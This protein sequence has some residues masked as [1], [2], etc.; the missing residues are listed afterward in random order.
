MLTHIHITN[1]TI[2]D[3]LELTL[4]PGMTVLTGETGAGKSIIIDALG[5]VLGGRADSSLVRHG[6]ERCNITATFT[7]DAGSLA[8]TWLHNYEFDADNDCIIRRT[9]SPDGK[10]KAYINGCPVT[11]QQLKELGERL[12]SIHGQHEHQTLQKKE[13]QRQL[14]DAFAGLQPLVAQVRQLYQQWHMQQKQVDDMLAQAKQ[15]EQQQAYL[16]FQLEEFTD[17]NLQPNELAELQQEHQLLANVDKILSVSQQGLLALSE[18]EEG[19]ALQLLE[20]AHTALAAL[21]STDSRLI[22]VTDLLSNALIQAEEAAT[23]LRGYVS[24]IEADPHYLQRVEERLS[25]IYELA[26]KHKIRPEELV[27]YFQRLT[28]QLQQLTNL[29]GQIE[30]LQ[31]TIKKLAAD[32]LKAANELTAKRQAAA[33]HLAELV[34]EQMQLLAMPGGRFAIELQSHAEYQPTG[35][36]AIE[37]LVSANPGYPLQPL[38][39]VASGGELSRISLAIQVITAQYNPIPTLIFD[40]VDVGIG[41]GTAEVV[42]RL[43]R[44]IGAKRQALCVT[45]LPQVASQGHQHL[46]VEKQVTQQTTITCIQTLDASERIVEIARMLGGVEITDQTLAHAKEM[47]AQV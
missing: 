45:H 5:L 23:E 13:R 20:Q 2:I 10:S 46:Q 32:Y 19:N 43:L 3:K 29:D 17:L 39:K 15:R 22:P 18:A 27:E 8:K 1:F 47:L 11:L 31:H 4:Q 41:G 9:L 14:L 44:T 7:L 37:F 26:R 24:Q 30:A 25:A 12:I 35:L 42:G 34:T 33:K 21:S 38:S 28:A 6:A 36:E 16:Q 40:E